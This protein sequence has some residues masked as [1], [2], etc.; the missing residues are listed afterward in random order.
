MAN[1]IAKSPCDGLL[2][3]SAG[4]CTLSEVMPEAITSIAFAKGQKKQVSDALKTALGLAYPAPNR[5]L[6]KDGGRLVWSGAQQAFL[7]G[8]VPRP[9]KGAA[10]T[11]QSDAWAVMRL[12]GAAAEDVLARLVPVDLRA[13]TFKR[14]HTARTMLFHMSC[15]ITRVGANAFDIMV[16]RSMAKTAVQELSTAMRSVAAQ[17]T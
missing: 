13:A 10:M 11:D 14:G 4:P 3:V 17:A 15:S 2:P 12:E 6:G 8:P 1:L 5:A 9:L 7:L 16:F